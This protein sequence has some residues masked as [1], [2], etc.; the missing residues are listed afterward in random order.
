[1]LPCLFHTFFFHTFFSYFFTGFWGPNS[2]LL[3][4]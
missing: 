3:L 2:S 4:A 1:L